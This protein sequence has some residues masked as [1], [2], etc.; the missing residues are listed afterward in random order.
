VPLQVAAMSSVLDKD[1][2]DRVRS[3]ELDLAPLLPASYASL[4]A[5]ELGRK[6]RKGV[7]VAFYASAPRGLWDESLLG[8]EMPGWDLTTNAQPA[9]VGQP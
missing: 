5:Q 3:S 9:D 2:S 8:E 4:M 6:L 7:A 1:L